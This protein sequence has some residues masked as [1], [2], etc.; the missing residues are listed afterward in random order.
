M[1]SKRNPFFVMNNRKK[2]PA[3][4]FK[5]LTM[6]V[7]TA[8]FL[9]SLL[10]AFSSGDQ[11][12][13][14]NRSILSTHDSDG[15]GLNDTLEG[16]LGTLPN[17]KY[18]DKDQ[19]GLYDFEEYLD[20]Y[21]TPDNTADTQKYNY[22]DSTTYED[23]LDIYHKFGFD[24][25]KTGYLRDT[26]NTERGGFTNYILWN[27]TFSDLYAG[28]NFG[29]GST[30]YINNTLLDV[31]FS[32][33]YAGGSRTLFTTYMNNIFTD[34]TFSGSNAGGTQGVQTIPAGPVSYINNTLTDVTF[35]GR[36][37]GG[38]EDG[39]VS[40][41]NNTLAN[42][43]YIEPSFGESPGI[44]TTGHT[45]YTNNNFDRVQFVQLEGG[46]EEYDVTTI[47]NTIINDSYDSDND[48]FGDI[49]ELLTGLYD[50]ES[51]SDRDGL[52]NG[53]EVTYNVSFGVDPLSTASVPELNWDFD[54]DGLSLSE[55]EESGTNPEDSDTDSDGL[56]DA[57][58]VTYN[59][60]FGV[61]PL[62]AVSTSDLNSDADGDGLSLSEE[63]ESGTNPEDSD[64]DSDGLNDA[65]EVT[66]SGS[67]GVDPLSTASVPE[68]N[69][70]ADGDGLSLSEEEESGTN[71]EDS[72][73]D[74]DG[75][76]DAW[77]V[78]Y[79]GAFGV[80]PLSAVFTS[81][82][83]SDADG[84]GLSLSEE[85]E[86]GTNPEDSDTDSDGLNDA[87]E[88]KYDKSYG[89]DPLSTASV[90]EL[91]WDADGDGLSLSE[92]EDANTDPELANEV[93]N[94]VTNGVTN[95]VTNEGSLT[96]TMFIAIFVILGIVAFVLRV[97][98]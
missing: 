75:L 19:D 44:S 84:D 70:D 5:K 12:G 23:T 34:V 93:T 10:F 82:L 77:E 4:L 42:V 18:G 29:E 40:Y 39:D 66:Y 28:G 6:L 50:P 72:D 9:F 30:T 36:G 59:G 45:N 76:N 96:F 60:A 47:G 62:S 3:F 61:N 1:T 79:N 37:A 24:S 49:F 83:N 14:T 81:N 52:N 56:N 80:N 46:R 65:W 25:N 54:M 86:S 94:G 57:W 73:T 68:L 32:G 17:D 67:Y 31:T 63:E 13:S 64:T 55:E 90:P 48:G 22:N 41:V 27:V 98:R 7:C 92:E 85:E 16:M 87:W 97:K 15:D 20:L 58:E 33:S 69:W 91:N 26:V 74:S 51:D 53:W 71:L 2:S 21:G 43:R 88:V 89:V 35:S 38:S 8:I 11:T 95:E 78:T